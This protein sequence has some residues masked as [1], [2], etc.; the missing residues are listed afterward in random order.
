[1]QTL[2]VAVMR[3]QGDNQDQYFFV[4]DFIDQTI[5]LV[6]ASGP[7]L[8][9]GEMLQVLHLPC[10]R[11]G[12]LLQLDEDVCDFANGGLVTTAFD[13]GQLCL[14]G[15]GKVYDVCHGLQGFDECHH[16]FLAFKS[17][18]SGSGTVGFCDIPLHGLHVA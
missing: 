13:D 16:V 7:R 11:S 17:R 15:L 3:S 8:G 4:V 2:F 6:D 10:A 5:L 1:M 12:V 18:E 9:E 14:G